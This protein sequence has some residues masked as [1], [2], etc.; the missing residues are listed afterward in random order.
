MKNQSGFATVEAVVAILMLSLGMMGLLATA[1]ATTQL[2][3]EG[4]Q[5]TYAST[6][7]T[8]RFEQL[9]SQDCASLSPGSQAVGR[10]TVSW[11]DQ[12]LPTGKAAKITVNVKSPTRSGSRTDTFST[13]VRCT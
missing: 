12:P 1:A 10:Y 11:S 5:Q 9:R 7:A 6:L 8:D 13:V 3:A 2:V 4:R